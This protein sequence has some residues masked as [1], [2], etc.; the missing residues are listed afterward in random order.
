M[1][2]ANKLRVLLWQKRLELCDWEV[3]IVPI[4][5]KQVTYPDDLDDKS[6]VGV[7]ILDK[8]ATIYHSR[9]LEEE[10]MEV[11]FEKGDEIDLREILREQIYLSLP[12]KLICHPDCRGLCPQC[13]INLN[14]GQCRC[15][16]TLGHPG[17]AKLK[18]L[19]I[20]GE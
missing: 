7:E 16:E 15:T 2:T 18:N 3:S 11:D 9:E 19:K 1:I 17:F 6:F 12:A 10:D 4:S 14:E 5:D 8:R 13:G 20:Q